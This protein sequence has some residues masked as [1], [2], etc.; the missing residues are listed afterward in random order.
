MTNSEQKS[1]DVRVFVGDT[2]G[3]DDFAC[4]FEDDGDTGYLYVSNRKLKKVVRH[5]Q[6]YNDAK[7]INPQEED[8]SVVWSSDGKKCGVIIFNG[9]R[10]IIDLERG[11]EGR[12]KM[13]DR[14]SPPITDPLWLKGFEKYLS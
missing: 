9:I 10:G 12:S 14:S 4:F 8:V 13:T 1:D 2:E 5:L 7:A 11:I 6:V 3:P